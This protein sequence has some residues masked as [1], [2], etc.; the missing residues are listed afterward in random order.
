[1]NTTCYGQ[2][3]RDISKHAKE[4]VAAFMDLV[5]QRESRKAYN[6]QVNISFNVRI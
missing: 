3:I 1:M 2:I 5:G 4:K 6:K